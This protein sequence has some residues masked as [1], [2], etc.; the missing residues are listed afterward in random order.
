MLKENMIYLMNLFTIKG[1]CCKV[2]SRKEVNCEK[3]SSRIGT[4]QKSAS[5]SSSR[6]A[7]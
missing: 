6:S 5:A 3:V 7:W 1:M 2:R 4:H